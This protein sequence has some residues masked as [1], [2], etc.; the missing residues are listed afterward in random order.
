MLAHHLTQDTKRGTQRSGVSREAVGEVAATQ[1]EDAKGEGW[2]P[3]GAS[4]ELE[5][6]RTQRRKHSN[7]RTE[8]QLQRFD[9]I[10]L[11]VRQQEN[12]LT[13]HARE[14]QRPR[15]SKGAPQQQARNGSECS[16]QDSGQGRRE[17]T[18]RQMLSNRKRTWR[19]C[20]G[21][22]LRA[23]ACCSGSSS[24]VP[25]VMRSRTAQIGENALLI[26]ARSIIALPQESR[27]CR[28]GQ[29]R[30]EEKSTEVRLEA[31][32]MLGGLL[33]RLVG[34]I[35]GRV[36]QLVDMLSCQRRQRQTRAER[37]L[38]GPSSQSE[39]EESES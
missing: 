37:R 25:P 14:R 6:G 3:H 27:L 10:N 9:F 1:T 26:R 12:L 16:R 35:L 15:A 22:I 29:F 21:S 34:V 36:P 17:R 28:V 32:G 30:E 8:Y 23:S 38:E 18:R 13:T 4:G 24:S 39:C 11:P 5:Q 20:V 19:G 7:S 33:K 31:S 2:G